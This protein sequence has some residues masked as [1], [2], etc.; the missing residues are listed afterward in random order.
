MRN[1]GKGPGIRPRTAQQIAV[2]EFCNRIRKLLGRG[3]VS[4]IQRGRRRGVCSCP[5]AKT[6]GSG[7]SVF[8][9]EIWIKGKER[10]EIDLPSAVIDFVEDFDEGYLP[11][12]DKYGRG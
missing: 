6:V 7:V 3:S 5:I 2:L 8:P 4:T 11:E 1:A 10:Q 9:R 12:F